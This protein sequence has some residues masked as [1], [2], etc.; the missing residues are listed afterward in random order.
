MGL[1]AANNKLTEVILLLLCYPMSISM[2]CHP[3]MECCCWLHDFYWTMPGTNICF[4]S[5]PLLA[6]FLCTIPVLCVLSASRSRG[7]KDIPSA[8]PPSAP[9]KLFRQCLDPGRL[10]AGGISSSVSGRT[11]PWSERKEEEQKRKE[12]KKAWGCEKPKYLE[13]ME[14][15][16][17]FLLFFCSGGI[18]RAFLGNSYSFYF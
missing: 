16:P 12:Q 3:A 5:S 18:Y 10:A 6:P 1:S 14:R 11:L 9:L 13:M 17:S 4:P 8:P 2:G 15:S 7:A